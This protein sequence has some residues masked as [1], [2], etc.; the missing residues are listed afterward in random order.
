MKLPAFR[1]N[2]SLMWSPAAGRFLTRRERLTCMGYSV[3]P[4]HASASGSPLLSFG[5]QHSQALVGN[6]M[7]VANI[8]CATAV[9]MAACRWK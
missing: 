7:H 5:P 2:S 6:A 4:E 9:G 1:T 3:Y 8:G